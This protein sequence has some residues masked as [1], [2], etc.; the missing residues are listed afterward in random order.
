M[1]YRCFLPLIRTLHTDAGSIQ[2]LDQL[3]TQVN[4]LKCAFSVV[5]LRQRNGVKRLLEL[6]LCGITA[7][8]NDDIFDIAVMSLIRKERATPGVRCCSSA[9]SVR[10][11][12][13]AAALQDHNAALCLTA[14]PVENLSQ[15]T[16]ALNGST[17]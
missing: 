3:I 13:A 5:Y 1:T 6:M 2:V 4:W 16:A 11:L 10:D 8:N 14:T 7:W 17:A 9:P 15:K 12:V